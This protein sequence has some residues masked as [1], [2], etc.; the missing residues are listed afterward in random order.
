[1]PGRRALA[2]MRG[3]HHPRQRGIPVGGDSY[4]QDQLCLISLAATDGVGPTSVRKLF[5]GAQASGRALAEILLCSPAELERRFDIP[6]KAALALSHARVSVAGGAAVADAL[7]GMDARVIFEGSRDYPGKLTRFLGDAA[8]PVLFLLGDPGVLKRTCVAVVG[9]RAPSKAAVSAARSFAA[10]LASAGVTVVSGGAVGIDTAGHAGA[11]ACGATAV[12]PPVGL[13]RFRWRG[14]RAADLERAS[15]CVVGQFAPDRC[16]RTGNALIRNRTIV[17]LADAVVAFEPR[18]RGGTWHA[19]LTGL[20]MRKPLFVAGR[21]ADAA[22]RHGMSR[23]LRL[24][25]RELDLRDMPDA[26]EF[27]QSV[28]AWR[29]PCEQAQ[30]PLFVEPRV[31]GPAAG[32]D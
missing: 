14:V 12:V 25:A 20:E 29:P 6:A 18:D 11:I 13:A 10:G 9:S 32:H 31:E 21:A 26:A 8:P 30:L 1:M 15:W 17:A 28:R 23:L 5:A 3:H 22:R 4:S 24:G 16:W 2:Q 27:Q 19:C 7:E